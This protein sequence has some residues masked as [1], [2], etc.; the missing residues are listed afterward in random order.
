MVGIFLELYKTLPEDTQS[1]L[2]IYMISSSINP[3]DLRKAE[4]NEYVSEYL[5]K[6]LEDNVLER[7]LQ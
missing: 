1:Q 4:E 2:T 7:L 6:P 5:V 3:E